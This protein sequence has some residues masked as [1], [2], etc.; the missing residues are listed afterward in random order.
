M[1]TKILDHFVMT[2][3]EY[4][5]ST[6][7]TVQQE[8]VSSS[9]ERWNAYLLLKSVDRTNEPRRATHTHTGD[10]APHRLSLLLYNLSVKPTY[11]SVLKLQQS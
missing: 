8:L 6:D 4:T 10:L 7:T 11:L 2:T 5:T 1:G 9:F 3:E